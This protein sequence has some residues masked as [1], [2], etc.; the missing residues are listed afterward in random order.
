MSARTVFAFIG[1]SALCLI[2]PINAR[3]ELIQTINIRLVA[4]VTTQNTNEGDTHI[5]H[6]KAV[7]ITT[8]DVLTMLGNATSNDFR[9]ATLVSVHRGEAYQV[10]RGTNVL[11]D[12][13]QFFSDGSASADV[14]DQTFDST[15]GKDFYHG[16]WLKNWTFDDQNGNRFELSGMIEEHYTA[17]TADSDGNQQVSDL[18]NYTCAGS[19][20]LQTDPSS[21]DG[22][23]TL[24]TGTV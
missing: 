7:R 1:L 11:A 24:Y 12:V 16:F 8:K 20:T 2:I 22:Q 5:E 21:S 3:A 18:Y 15:T 9:G 23:F 10:R 14:I 4:R 13:S 17:K 19:G 6:M